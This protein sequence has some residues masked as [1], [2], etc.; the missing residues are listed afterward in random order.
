M[1][2]PVMPVGTGPGQVM[3]QEAAMPGIVV[4]IDG[5]AHSQRSLEWAMKEAALRHVPLTVLAVHPVAL[6]AWTRAPITYPVDAEEVENAK[7]AA[8]E[9]V[10]KVASQIGGERPAVTV[11]SVSG[12]PAEE[13]IKAGEG[14]DML[15]VGSRG[16]GG[17]GRLLLGS[18]SSQVT[19]HAPC[20]VVVVPGP[21]D[22]S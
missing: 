15:V 10:D 7:S 12:S 4:G 13:L 11:Q 14:A 17:F 9:S 16:S 20:P 21:A 6:S 22:E 19:H 8:Q 18:V 1:S 5:S 3:R 2:E